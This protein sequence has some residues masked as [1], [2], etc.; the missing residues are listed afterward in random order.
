[1]VKRPRT[2]AKIQ[3]ML[4]RPVDPVFKEL[5]VKLKEPDSEIM[6]RVLEKLM[7]LDQ[8]RIL[9][10][11]ELPAAEIAEKLN[12]SQATVEKQTQVLFEKG[13]AF[14]GRSGWHLIRSWGALHD[15]AGAAN[16]KYDNDE[17]FDLAF[18]EHEEQI[19]NRVDEVRS[20]KVK[21]F[22][23]GMRVIPKWQSIKDIP[24]VLPVEDTREILKAMQPLAL[25]EC[26]CKKIDRN[27]ECQDD[28][29]TMTCLTLGKSAEYNLKRGAGK[30][31][32]VEEASALMDSFDEHHLVHLSGNR[33]TMP[34]L[35][36]N[37]HTCCCGS[38]LRNRSVKSALNLS[39][40]VKSRFIAVVNPSKCVSCGV[41]KYQVC[42]V[43]AVEM[44]VY[45][46][47]HVERAYTNR[48]ECIGC[49]LCVISCPS[50]ARKMELV[51]PPEHIPSPDAQFS[52]DGTD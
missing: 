2:E 10:S 42:P 5:S 49:G 22:R 52:T 46:G 25:V 34:G 44:K 24:G 40:I 45:P 1:M 9:N 51:R 19:Q 20:G 43:G 29:P 35:L 16:P 27:R 48:E 37:C 23:T 41:C 8:A 33:N 18:A 3:E 21:V 32:T 36:C 4:K 39:S 28:V 11:I 14:P 7:T 17:F 50:G 13:L 38:F 47:G 6:P 12:M 26:A 15:S 31:L 30:K